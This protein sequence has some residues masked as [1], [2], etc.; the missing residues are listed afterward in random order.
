MRIRIGR[1]V[2]TTKTL[3][4][5]KDTNLPKPPPEL[6]ELYTEAGFDTAME[7]RGFVPKNRP[8]LHMLAKDKLQ[9]HGRTTAQRS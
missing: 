8:R 4:T 6:E 3:L 9:T 7:Y 5:D 1:P 2:K